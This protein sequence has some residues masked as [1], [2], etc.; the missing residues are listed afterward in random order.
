VDV[1]HLA[2]RLSFESIGS[3][4]L[5]FVGLQHSWNAKDS[6]VVRLRNY[7]LAV[8]LVASRSQTAIRPPRNRRSIGLR[9]SAIA[10]LKCRGAVSGFSRRPLACEQS[11]KL[12]LENAPCVLLRDGKDDRSA[13]LDI[14]DHN[15]PDFQ[16]RA[17]GLEDRT[18]F[19]KLDGLLEVARFDQR[20]ASDNVLGLGK[21]AV[22]H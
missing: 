20:I 8:V 7:F 2:T 6:R 13:P 10:A 16:E 22:Y 3:G 12:R 1:H 17:L 11:A 18:A 9:A 19:G 14:H 5:L 21:R 4:G 15:R